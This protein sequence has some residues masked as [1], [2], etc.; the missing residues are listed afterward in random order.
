[1]FKFLTSVPSN[2]LLNTNDGDACVQ[3]MWTSLYPTAVFCFRTHTCESGSH[4]CSVSEHWR[5][6][7]NTADADAYV[8][9]I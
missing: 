8:L 7:L 6:Y 3:N 1:M 9:S 5:R 2:R 4:I